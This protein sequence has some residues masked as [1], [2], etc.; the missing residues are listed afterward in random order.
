LTLVTGELWPSS[1]I[2]SE[3]DGKTV[4]NETVM[5]GV[6]HL[7][8]YVFEMT[9]T[10][11]KQLRAERGLPEDV[12][13]PEE[14]LPQPDEEPVEVIHAEDP[15]EAVAEAQAEGFEAEEE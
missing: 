11:I 15:E 4:A 3:E 8:N 5:E 6:E 7:G 13:V 12:A 9:N 14:A 1:R 10:R 2:L